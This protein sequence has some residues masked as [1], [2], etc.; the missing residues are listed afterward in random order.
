MHT[1]HVNMVKFASK[2]DVGYKTIK[3][4]LVLMTRTAPGKIRE[5][6]LDHDSISLLL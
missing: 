2:E 6:W 3:G 1:D 4:Y 5:R